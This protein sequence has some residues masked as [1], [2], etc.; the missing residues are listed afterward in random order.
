MSQKGRVHFYHQRGRYDG[1]AQTV[2]RGPEHEHQRSLEEKIREMQI[3]SLSDGYDNVEGHFEKRIIDA[4][5]SKF[6]FRLDDPEFDFLSLP[7]ISPEIMHPQ[8]TIDITASQMVITSTQRHEK[9][10]IPLSDA[11]TDELTSTFSA[12]FI[13][14]SFSKILKKVKMGPFVDGSIIVYIKDIR[15]MPI[16]EE[17]MRLKEPPFTPVVLKKNQEPLTKA[18]VAEY[19]RWKSLSTHRLICTDPSPDVARAMSVMD[20]RSKMWTSR[21]IE[22]P[23]QKP[24]SLP[25]TKCPIIDDRQGLKQLTQQQLLFLIPQDF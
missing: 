18:E 9:V 17:Y 3:R 1:A 4:Y 2:K 25:T 22:K 11:A 14:Q 6:L 12:G 15:F 10:T 19:E 20:H 7:K 23:P 24:P 16:R 13:N 5:H 8:L 21:T